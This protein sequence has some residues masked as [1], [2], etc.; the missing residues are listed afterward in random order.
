MLKGQPDNQDL[1]ALKQKL[2]DKI[3]PELATLQQQKG[4]QAVQMVEDTVHD[5]SYPVLQYPDKIKSI[6]LDKDGQFS[7]TLLGIKGQYWLLDGDRVINMRK[8]SGYE[9]TVELD[10]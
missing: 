3:A 10:E 5:I 9:L 4:L 7:G 6:N 8:Y 1:I 2:L